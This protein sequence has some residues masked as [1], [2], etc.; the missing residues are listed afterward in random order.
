MFAFG[1]EENPLKGLSDQISE[2]RIM[3]S[4]NKQPENHGNDPGIRR[5][6]DTIVFKRKYSLIR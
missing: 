2:Q 4:N 3:E 6:Q 5:T 1:K